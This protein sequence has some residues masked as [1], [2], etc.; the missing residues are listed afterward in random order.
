MTQKETIQLPDWVKV[1]ATVFNKQDKK[2]YKITEIHPNTI[3]TEMIKESGRTVLLQNPET[4]LENYKFY[5]P[6]KEYN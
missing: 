1:G 4:F 3:E 2:L 6:E 5:T